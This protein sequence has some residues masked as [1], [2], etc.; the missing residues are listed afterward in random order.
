MTR[1]QGGAALVDLV[2]VLTFVVVGRR[3]HHE[4]GALVTGTLKVA[5]PFVIALALGWLVA[6]AWRQPW[7]AWATGIP[8]WLVT[9]IGGVLLRRFAFGRSTAAAFV[10]VATIALGA[11]LVGWRVVAGWLAERRR[12]A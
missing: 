1:R 4:S 8:V 2:A 5:A 6:R 3:S 11:F 9:V 12:P 10:V 7:D